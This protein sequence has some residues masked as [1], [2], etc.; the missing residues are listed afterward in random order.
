MAYLTIKDEAS[1]EFEEKKSIFIGNVRRIYNEDEAKK[2]INEIRSKHR[3][4]THN[5]YAYI[6]GENMGI[7]RYS[8]DGEPQGTAGVPVLDVVKKNS[9]TDIVVVV[10][11]YFG[12]TLLGAGGL[13]RAYSKG[14]SEAIKKGGI[15]EKVKGCAL[16]I[17]IDYDQLG[18]IQYICGQNYWHIED[19]A[20]T[21]K[22]VVKLYCEISN[23]E[24]IKNSIVESTSG[25][26]IFTESE[27]EYYFKLNNR[28]FAEC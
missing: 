3:E 9:I 28:L 24:K 10:T 25:K 4:A 12:G 23:V 7:Q 26:A 11:R 20:Y 18:K 21:D 27:K 5:V 13:V 22:V 6:I 16:Y 14:A 2:F 15:V 19:T 8:D 1:S 17:T